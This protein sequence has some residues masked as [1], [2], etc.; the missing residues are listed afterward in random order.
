MELSIDTTLQIRFSDTDAMGVVWHGNYLRFFEDGREAFGEK[1][2]LE[3]LDVYNAGYFTPIVKTDINYKNSIYYGDKV[4]MITRYVNTRSAK[5][6]FE[7]ELINID[8]GL[9]IA[10]G[11][12]T[13]VFLSVK[14][15]ELRLDNPDFYMKWKQGLFNAG[16]L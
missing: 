7:Y 3:Y 9:I 4:K 15:R 1:Y 16:S 12:T 13:Q 14:E 11:S 5:I 2:G 10:K 6:V 8:S